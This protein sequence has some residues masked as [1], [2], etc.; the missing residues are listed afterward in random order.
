MIPIPAA[1]KAL[2]RLWPDAVRASLRPDA[3]AHAYNL[4][5]RCGSIFVA[6]F[7][8]SVALNAFAA[9]KTSKPKTRSLKTLIA[10]TM[11]K[12]TS[13]DLDP[14]NAAEIDVDKSKATDGRFLTKQVIYKSADSPDGYKHG[15]SV[16]Y[17]VDKKTSKEIP[18][19]L[20]W[21]ILVL[22]RKES[23]VIYTEGYTMRA[24]LDGKMEKVISI[25]GQYGRG[26]HIDL[27]LDSAE[28]ARVF[29]HEYDFY[30][31]ISVNLPVVYK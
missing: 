25:K 11:S 14:L 24:S 13:V 6:A 31:R 7:A 4:R 19:V 16:L 5:S 21:D 15:F 27:A 12:G 1:Q 30:T 22:A 18:F 20:I 8:L 3:P 23:D 17:T 2:E 9:S 26:Q 29:D 10:T 28:A